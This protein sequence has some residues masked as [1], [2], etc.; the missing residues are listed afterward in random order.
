MSKLGRI[1]VLGG[2][3]SYPTLTSKLDGKKYAISKVYLWLHM[4]NDNMKPKK[5]LKANARG[6][7]VNFDSIQSQADYDKGL[8]D[9]QVFI[10]EVNVSYGT[11]IKLRREEGDK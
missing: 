8:V 7:K 2:Q 10:D 3:M 1:A 6:T 4:L 11:E 5:W 9:L